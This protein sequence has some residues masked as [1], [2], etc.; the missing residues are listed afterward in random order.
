MEVSVL[1]KKLPQI[2]AKVLRRFHVI[3]FVL[4]A[5]GGLAI[6]VFFV[7]DLLNASSDEVEPSTSGSP[8]LDQQTIDKLKT[9]H[10]SNDGNIPSLNRQGERSSPF[11]E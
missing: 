6:A 7:N 5:I 3:I 8:T 10:T 1:F 9:F 11:Q 4:I 2:I